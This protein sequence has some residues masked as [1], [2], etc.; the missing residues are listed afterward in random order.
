VSYLFLILKN[1]LAIC[2]EVAPWL[3]LGLILAGLLKVFLPVKL[4]QRF[5]GGSGVGPLFRA[6]IVGTPLPLC[7]CSVLPT[8]IQLHRSGA[9]KG[10]TA[11]FLVATP[12][13]GADSIALSYVL[14]GPAMTVLRPV[15]AIISAV[16]TGLITE[17]GSSFSRTS[18][19]TTTTPPT[20]ADASACCEADDCTDEPATGAR[21]ATWKTVG[22]AIVDLLDDIALWLLVG[23]LLA[24][25][26]E[27]LAPANSL[28]RFGSGLLPMLAIAAISIPMYICAT[29]STPIAASMLAVGISPGTVL[30]FLLAGPATNIA[31][32]AI[33]R[34]ELGTA[35]TAAYLVGVVASAIGLGLLVDVLFAQWNIE[36]A[37][38]IH[39]AG[40]IIPK[41]VSLAALIVL[42]LLM[43]KP[44]R[45]GVAKLA[46]KR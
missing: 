31:S 32:A 3:L 2:Q 39:V 21:E 27:T 14:L 10:A 6:A 17:W 33:L 11:S 29:A 35:A 44:L 46:K 30:V 41:W 7:S 34:R 38:Q 25:I 28:N 16:L 36:A 45:R 18:T 12:E 13:N 26:L 8:A 40:E 9:S 15:A 24:A 23:I 37:R 22:H 43:I 5:L 19:T 42:A 20:Q 4:L 1:S